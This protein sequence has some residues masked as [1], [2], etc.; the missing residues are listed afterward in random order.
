MPADI[1]REELLRLA[2]SGI[3]GWTPDNVTNVPAARRAVANGA[4]PTDL[5]V[6]MSAAAYEAVFSLLFLL[7]EGAGPD[8]DPDAQGWAVTSYPQG[9]PM[10]GLHEDVLIFDPTGRDGSDLFA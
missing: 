4:D 6:A 3:R 10:L 2:W 9:E 7:D 1:E 8:S 5:A